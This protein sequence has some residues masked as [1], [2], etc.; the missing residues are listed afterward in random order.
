MK[1]LGRI[2]YLALIVLFLY[3][4][5]GTLM[6]L[7]FNSGKSMSAWQGFSVKWYQEMF[8][9]QEIM[10]ALGNTLT[11]ALWASVIAT[12]VGVLACIG[13][14]AMSEKKRSFF[15]GVNN[16]PLLNADIVTGISIMMSFL[17]FGIS[18]SYGTVLFAHIT[19]CI[20]YVILSVMPKFKQLENIT[21]EAAMDLGATPVYAFFKVVLPDI[22]PGIVSGFLLSFTMSVDDF[23]ITHFTRGAGINTLST[24]IYSQVKI[25][26]RPT[27]YALSTLLFVTVLVVLLAVNILSSDAGKRRRKAGADGDYYVKQ[28]RGI[29][30]KGAMALVVAMLLVVFGLNQYAGSM[31]GPQDQGKLYVYCFGDYI[32]PDLIDQFEEETGYEVVMDYFDTN[33]E[34]Y[35]VIKNHT[36]SYDVICASD[37]MIDRMRNEELLEPI[38]VR[39][40]PNLENLQDNVKGFIEEFDPGMK[41]SVP[42]TWGTYGII[43]NTTMID[44]E[45]DSW[46]QLWDKKYDGQIIMPNSIREAYVVAGRLLGYSINTTDERE[47]AEMTQKLI[48]QKPLVYSFA[49]DNARDLMIG[50]AAALAVI[51]SGDVL[52]AQEENENLE[53]VVPKEGTEVWTDCWA[54]PKRVE[55]KEAALAWI[56]FMLRG[57]I[58]RINFEYLTYAIPNKEIA[59][60]TAGEV[61]NPS[62]EI[63]ANC[64][65]LKN[66]GSAGDDLYSKY[67]KQY[68]G[69]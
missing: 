39:Y 28:K 55:N 57:D 50:D 15:M 3:L 69:K 14:N 11:I 46:A 29:T 12:V 51:T 1:K 9:S 22:M 32:D 20:P 25:G 8:H 27:L 10:E 24:L 61:L 13:L 21:Y 37:Y 63:L 53:Y 66:L 19:F 7:S 58:A 18:L 60:L 23:V 48:Q 64:E 45:I 31:V 2:L 56:D 16:I 47:L 6:A 43:Y 5:I 52:Y 62:D 44:E 33:E 42:H 49:N 34:M 26:V 38:D 40:I 4:P 65:T 68:K 54:I 59:D 17:L 67:W 30:P 41:Y 36:A 35:P